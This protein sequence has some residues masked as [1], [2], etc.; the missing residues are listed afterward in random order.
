MDS[1]THIRSE[2]WLVS[3]CVAQLTMGDY[4]SLHVH[5]MVR[6]SG[7]HILHMTW[8]TYTLYEEWPYV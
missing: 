3:L 8:V 7:Q 6:A 5:G 4:T 1:T 2:V